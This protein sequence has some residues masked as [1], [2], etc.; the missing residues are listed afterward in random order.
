MSRSFRAAKA[1]GQTFPRQNPS[2]ASERRTVPGTEARSAEPGPSRV[3]LQ[4][5][6]QWPRQRSRQHLSPRAA[7][8]SHWDVDNRERRFTTAPGS[9]QKRSK[10][11]WNEHTEKSSQAV[12]RNGC[13][14][15]DHLSSQISAGDAGRPGKRVTQKPNGASPRPQTPREGIAAADYARLRLP[16]GLS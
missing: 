15:Q 11:L 5:A 7:G 10:F 1:E 4:L 13:F 14:F 16:R 9:R 6:G 3:L 2:P 8:K 12:L